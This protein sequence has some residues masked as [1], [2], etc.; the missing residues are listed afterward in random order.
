MKTRELENEERYD[1]EQ[2]DASS[3]K[4]TQEEKIAD[5]KKREHETA[6]EELGLDMLKIYSSCSSSTEG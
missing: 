5:S 2:K 6:T 4:Y 3:E 1:V